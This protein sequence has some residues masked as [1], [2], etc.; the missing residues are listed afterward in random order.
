MT[1]IEDMKAKSWMRWVLYA[2][3]IYN[4]V[5]GA[6]AITVPLWMFRAAGMELPRYPEFWQ[7]IGMIVGVYGIGY[8]IAASDRILGESSWSNRICRSTLVR[9]AASRLWTQYC[10]E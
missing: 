5:W 1:G 6:V 4:M 2:A 3:G 9:E 10:D 7:C 8:I